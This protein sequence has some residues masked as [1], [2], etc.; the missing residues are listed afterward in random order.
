MK[1]DEVI[2]RLALALKNAKSDVEFYA[3]RRQIEARV[4]VLS[5]VV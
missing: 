4:R 3:I 5:L 1:R 2:A